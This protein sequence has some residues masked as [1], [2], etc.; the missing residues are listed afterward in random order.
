MLESPRGSA[1]DTS[2]DAHGCATTVEIFAV[3]AVAG[4]SVVQWDHRPGAQHVQEAAADLL[5]SA[6]DLSNLT[7]DEQ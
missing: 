2:C 1:I 6:L 3:P 7:G 5:S 4:A